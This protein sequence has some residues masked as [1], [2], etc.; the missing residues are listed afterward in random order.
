MIALLYIANNVTHINRPTA[1]QTYS[2]WPMKYCNSDDLHEG[3]VF[4]TLHQNMNCFVFI[5]ERDG[6]NF[7]HNNYFNFLFAKM[8]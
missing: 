1:I 8:Q 3:V 5:D 4:Q 6:N 2:Q 7:T